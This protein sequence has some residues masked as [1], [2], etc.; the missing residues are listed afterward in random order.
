[1]H[2]NCLLNFHVHN[3]WKMLQNICRVSFVVATTTIKQQ[4]EFFIDNL[5]NVSQF[6]YI[7]KIYMKYVCLTLKLQ[8]TYIGDV[9]V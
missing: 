3:P 1:M 5:E 2:F 4:I 7:V 9:H 6:S 8:T